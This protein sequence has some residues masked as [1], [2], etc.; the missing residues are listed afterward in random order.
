MNE[1]TEE[2]GIYHMNETTDRARVNNSVQLID[3]TVRRRR[4]GRNPSTA[5]LKHSY[6]HRQ[7][8]A[9]YRSSVLYYLRVRQKL[10]DCR[11]EFIHTSSSRF[12]A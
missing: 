2:M 8:T 1:W 11:L 6:L 7:N 12:W 4:L 9:E 5:C 10:P 3:V